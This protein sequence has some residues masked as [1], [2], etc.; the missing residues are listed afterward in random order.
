MYTSPQREN[1]GRS[2][3]ECSVEKFHT[4]QNC[5]NDDSRRDAVALD[6]RGYIQTG[7]LRHP[8]VKYGQ[9]WFEA[10]DALKLRLS[11][12][13]LGDDSEISF[14]LKNVAETSQKN[15]MVVR[16]DDGDVVC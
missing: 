9:G 1:R 5:E 14:L 8:G 10:P 4:I 2:K 6:N 13:A 15:R 16:K 7:K 3:I 11:L 12:E